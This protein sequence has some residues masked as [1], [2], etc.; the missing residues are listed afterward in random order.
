MLFTAI[1]EREAVL[2][3]VSRLLRD[4]VSQVLS[5]GRLQLDAMRMGFREATPDV[6]GRA[7]RSQERL[8]QATEQLR[9]ISNELKPSIVERAGL[10]L[11][12][13]RLTGKV[14]LKFSG[15][16]RLHFDASNRVPTILYASKNHVVLKSSPGKGTS[17]RAS[18]PIPA[19]AAS[20][21]AS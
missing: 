3:R 7:G 8:E 20:E 11:A 4:D 9:D 18:F 16:L 17:I 21:G 14:R 19:T 5:A 15:S 10:Q 13:Y 12:L 1:H 2:A 6:E